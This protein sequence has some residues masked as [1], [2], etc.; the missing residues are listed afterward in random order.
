MLNS[1]P[2][3]MAGSPASD[4]RPTLTAWTASQLAASM[5]RSVSPAASN[6]SLSSNFAI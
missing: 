2:G 3:T 6:N 1:G 4:N 5:A